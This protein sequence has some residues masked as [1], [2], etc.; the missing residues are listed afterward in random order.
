M[1]TTDKLSVYPYDG[2]TDIPLIQGPETPDPMPESPWCAPTCPGFTVSI[3][4]Q[5]GSI[6]TV[7]QFTLSGPNGQVSSKLIDKNNS[8]LQQL[9]TT[10]WAMIIPL[11]GLTPSTNYTATFIGTV[12]KG[13]QTQQITKTWSFTTRNASVSFNPT[14]YF[15][16]GSFLVSIK[17]P[18]GTRKADGLTYAFKNP[19][20]CASGYQIVAMVGYQSI[21]IRPA[22]GSSAPEFDTSPLVFAIFR[23]LLLYESM[24]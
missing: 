20:T 14:K 1:T 17:T 12:T 19:N 3:Q 23:G 18:S 4:S 21:Y 24:V 9:N 8:V 13:N 7:Q 5:A 2:A 16:D 15:Q 11:G 10:N 22:T 6:L